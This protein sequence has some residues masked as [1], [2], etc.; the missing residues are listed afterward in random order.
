MQKIMADLLVIGPGRLGM[1]VARAW[2][3]AVPS[4][5][6]HLKFRSANEARKEALAGEGLH[7]LSEE[8]PAPVSKCDVVIFIIFYA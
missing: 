4:S 1:L 5:T 7:V 2:Q 6:I 3:S 8:A